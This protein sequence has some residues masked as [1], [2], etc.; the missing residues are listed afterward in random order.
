MGSGPGWTYGYSV[1]WWKLGYWQSSF[2]WGLENVIQ[3][4]RTPY[5]RSVIFDN[6]SVKTYMSI[7]VS[8]YSMH[9]NTTCITE[10]SCK[11]NEYTQTFTEKGFSQPLELFVRPDEYLFLTCKNSENFLYNSLDPLPAILPLVCNSTSSKLTLNLTF[12]G[13]KFI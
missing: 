13:S 9:Q 4:I 2:R 6:G 12:D 10:N 7:F 11:I 8:H 1:H 5:R 3:P